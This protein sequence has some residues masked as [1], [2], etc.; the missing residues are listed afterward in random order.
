MLTTSGLDLAADGVDT[1]VSL[2]QGP[3]EAEGM[4]GAEGGGDTLAV[5]SVV[6]RPAPP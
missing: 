3:G 1:T 2:P 5:S 6:G 4:G